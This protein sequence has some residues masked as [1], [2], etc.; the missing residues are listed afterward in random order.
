MA[1]SFQT[2]TIKNYESNGWTVLKI[3]NLSDNGYPD[4]LCMKLGEKD[5]WIE[6]KEGKDTLKELQKFRIDELN[7]LGK[8][9]FCLHDKQGL[10]YPNN[11]EL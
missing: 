4:L 6:C 7:K 5:N 8:I 11:I 3:I 2:K 10:I 9:A 1:S